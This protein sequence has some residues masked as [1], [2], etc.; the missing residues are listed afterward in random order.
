MEKCT[1]CP[2]ECNAHRRGG[3]LG[4]CGQGANMRV[5]RCDLHFFEEPPISGKRG[6]GTIFFSGCSLRCVFCQNRA[7]SRGEAVGREVSVD[8]LC[9]M[10]LELQSRGAHNI[11]LVTPTHFADKIALSLGRVKDKLNIP[12]VYNTSGYEKVETLKLFCGLVDVYMPDFKYISGEL[13]AAY[14]FAPD[15]A[16]VAEAA[17][18]EM[19]RQV[20]ACRY[21]EDGM[22]LRGMIVRHLVLPSCRKDSIAVLGRLAEILPKE[23]I[24]ISVMSQYTPEFA[25]GCGYKN[26]ERRLTDFEYSSVAAEAD[27][28][29]FSGFI[30]GRGSASA[31]Y[32]PDFGEK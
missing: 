28:L 6:S 4:Y 2:R 10:M 18:C 22:L 23:D 19:Y 5:A 1:L 26:L 32:T 13:S 25:M 31:K 14:S 11:N 3:E 16:E 12:V 17:L 15:Y 29:G 9:Q 20:G 27:R 7:I 30:Q 8:E 24:L 21:G